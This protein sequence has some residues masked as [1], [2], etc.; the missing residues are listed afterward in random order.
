[1]PGACWQ[2]P[3]GPDSDTYT[4]GRHPVTHIAYEDAAAYAAW[5][6]KALPTEAEWERAAR[7]GLEGARFAWGDEETPGGARMANTWQGEFPW[8]NTLEDGY[9]GTS[10]VGEFPPNGLGLLDACG[11]VWEWTCDWFAGGH[12]QPSRGGLLPAAAQ[13][14]D[15]APHHQ[16]RLAPVRAELLPPLPAGGAPG[17]VGGQL[18]QPPRLPLHRA[19]RLSLRPPASR[20][21]A[22]GAA[23]PPH[24]ARS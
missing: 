17:P 3:E 24:G 11:N 22:R 4:R 23:R 6:G 7:G 19:R 21:C 16:G 10:P 13:R 18:D 20:P 8:Q 15:P 5:A 14:R 9:A 2:R 12:D 1:M